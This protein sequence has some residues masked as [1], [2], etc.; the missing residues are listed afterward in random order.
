MAYRVIGSY[1]ERKL[2]GDIVPIFCDIGETKDWEH[3]KDETSGR[4]WPAY[5]V[6]A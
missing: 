4:V 3:P 1:K 2:S 5:S 6:N